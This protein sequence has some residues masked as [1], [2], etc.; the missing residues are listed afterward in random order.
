MTHRQSPSSQDGLAHVSPTRL[1]AVAG[2]PEFRD[3]VRGLAFQHVDWVDPV[4]GREPVTDR[5]TPIGLRCY[6][7]EKSLALSAFTN[8][9]EYP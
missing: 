3:P 1:S 6:R 4:R 7:T 8:G 5:R 9:T 2:R